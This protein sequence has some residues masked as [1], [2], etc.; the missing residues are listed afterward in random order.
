MTE[1][2]SRSADDPGLG[3]RFFNPSTPAD[4]KRRRLIFIGVYVVSGLMIIW[5]VYPLF[6]EPEPLVFGL[7]LPLVWI[8]TA[9][10]VG[11]LALLWLF[12]GEPQ[13][14]DHV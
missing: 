7:P 8:V 4:T 11:F 3:L 2:P 14:D 6:A 5:P 1:K 12:R 13:D 9:L 10:V